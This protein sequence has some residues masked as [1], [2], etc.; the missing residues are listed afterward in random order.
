MTPFSAQELERLRVTYGPFPHQVVHLE[1][2]V[3][4]DDHAALLPYRKGRQ[5]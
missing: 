5:A 3:A 1:D 2:G 4:Q